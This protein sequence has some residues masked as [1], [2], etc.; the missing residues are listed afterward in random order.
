MRAFSR[1]FAPAARA[2][3]R[4][5]HACHP[6]R[7]RCSMRPQQRPQPIDRAARAALTRQFLAAA[8]ERA[9]DTGLP[10][11]TPVDVGLPQTAKVK[12]EPTASAAR[13]SPFVNRNEPPAPAE[14]AA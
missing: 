2:R 10:R 6:Q 9:V 1:P 13:S 14:P 11:L 8:V 3:A 4:L 12:N 5:A 7:G